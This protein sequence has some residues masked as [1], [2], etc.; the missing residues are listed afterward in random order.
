VI[1]YATYIRLVKELLDGKEV[2]R[3]AMSEELDRATEAYERARLGK[4]WR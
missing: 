4:K 2:I 3:K 1:G